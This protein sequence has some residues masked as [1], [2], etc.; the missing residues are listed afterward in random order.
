MLMNTNNDS[1]SGER[2]TL[3]S[4]AGTVVFRR[5]SEGPLFLIISSS[6]G[7]HWVLPT[8]HIDPGE[9]PEN[10][11]LRELVEEAGILGRIVGFLSEQRFSTPR[12]NFVTHYFLVE[13]IG[14]AAASEARNYLWVDEHI[15][16]DLLSF[17]NTREALQ[18][19]ARFLSKEGRHPKG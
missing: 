1:L 8:G 19:G 14:E 18:Q 4:H 12:G 10:A 9:S 16:R 5:T 13:E 17:E 7:R 15:A 6:D 2:D 11:A 3:P